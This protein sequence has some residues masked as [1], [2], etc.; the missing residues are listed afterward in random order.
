MHILITYVALGL[1]ALFFCM[2]FI[3]ALIFRL[4]THRRSIYDIC[5]NMADGKGCLMSA[6]CVSALLV[7]LLFFVV[8]IGNATTVNALGQ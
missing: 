5:A 6:I 2:T 3:L 8:A 7:S 1:G 4:T